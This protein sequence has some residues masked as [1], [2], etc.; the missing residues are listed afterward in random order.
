MI[1]SACVACLLCVSIACA[2]EEEPLDAVTAAYRQGSVA[3]RLEIEIPREGAPPARSAMTVALRTGASPVVSLALGR[4]YPLRV[5]AEPGR[6]IAWRAGDRE[7]VFVAPL[8]EP[9][10]RGAIEAVLPPLLA[11]QIDLAFADEPGSLLA[12][13]PPLSWSLVASGERDRYAGVSMDA[14]LELTAGGD[15][16]LVAME[17]RR[18]GR[19]V[20]RAAIDAVEVDPA[21]FEPPSLEG[22]IVATLSELGETPGPVRAGERM[23]D[24][25]GFDA[26]GRVTTLRGVAGEGGRVVMLAVVARL[27]E[28]RSRLAGELAEAQL[29]SL[30]LMLDARVVVLAVGEASTARLFERVMRTTRADADRVGAIAVERAPAWLGEVGEGV[31]LS[32]DGDAWMLLERHR[33]ASTDADETDVAAPLESSTAPRT[34]AERLAEAVGAA[35]RSDR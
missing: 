1:R 3:D 23:G 20:A 14:S 32:V 17:A 16:R 31:A 4:G 7:R 27:P 9:F 13:L 2:Q 18:D 25:I 21:W 10:G 28:E 34:L 22:E 35:M 8:P 6:L 26:R 11:P 30:A 29:A 24:V 5:V 19:V 33:I 15:G 12:F